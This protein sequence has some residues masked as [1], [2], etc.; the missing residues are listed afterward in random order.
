MWIVTLVLLVW[1]GPAHADDTA[2]VQAAIN[3][4]TPLEARTY[5]ISRTLTVSNGQAL[6]GRGLMAT[7]LQPTLDLIGQPVV[8][9]MADATIVGRPQLRD[10]S[11]NPL[12][13][14]AAGY[15]G[16]YAHGVNGPVDLFLIQG[17]R[18]ENGSKYV[19]SFVCQNVVSSRM[20]FSQFWNYQ[21]NTFTAAW[22][23]CSDWTIT[24]SEFHMMAPSPPGGAIWSWEGSHMIRFFGGNV[25]LWPGPGNYIVGPGVIPVAVQFYIGG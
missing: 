3:T 12:P 15:L 1:A 10:F 9:M 16:I 20:D 2:L 22:L 23:G 21:P 24:G 19:L 25:S 18:I 14:G 6:I 8:E 5:T 11:V 7:I 4:S 17:V 13:A